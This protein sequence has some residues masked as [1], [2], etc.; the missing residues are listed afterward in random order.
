MILRHYIPFLI[1]L[2]IAPFAVNAETL[3]R[4]YEYGNAATANATSGAGVPRGADFSG[5]IS[6]NYVITA[7]G[8][9]FWSNSDHGSAIFE[10]PAVNCLGSELE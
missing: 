10:D 6:G 9:D 1:A 5:S 8:T 4:L 3:D 7:G 2:A